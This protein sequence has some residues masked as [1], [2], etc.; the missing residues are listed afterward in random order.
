[1]SEQ[2]STNPHTGGSYQGNLLNHAIRR[3][4]ADLNRLFLAHALDPV[5]REDHWFQLPA[6]TV[7]Q[8]ERAAPEAL[9]RAACTPLALFELILPAP[10]EATPCWQVGAVGDAERPSTNRSRSEARRSF[11][12]VALGVVRRLAEG[13]PLASRI[14]FGLAPASEIRLSAL[15]PSEVFRWASWQG[16]VRPR[17]P[18][19]AHFWSLLAGAATGTGNDDLHWAYSTGLCLLGR[20]DHD[21]AI[22]RPGATSRRPRSGYRR[23]GRDDPDVP[24]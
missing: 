3:D 2:N 10:D 21:L 16:L 13:V 19:H 8:F 18:S 17:W 24:C 7:L 12:L 22:A 4:I 11:G 20:C 14:A 15:S 5:H 6:P 1:M 23:G 9:E